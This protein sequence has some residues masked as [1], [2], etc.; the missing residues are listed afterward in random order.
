[1]MT[2]TIN[3]TVMPAFSAEFSR[4]SAYLKNSR[5]FSDFIKSRY[6]LRNNWGQ[7]DGKRATLV[8]G[9]RGDEVKMSDR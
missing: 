3:V 4:F 7:G 9:R 1:M 6:N 8:G 5:N 2:A